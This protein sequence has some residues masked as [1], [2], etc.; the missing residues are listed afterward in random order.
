MLKSLKYKVTFL[1][2]G[3]TLLQN[4]TF[5]NGFGAIVGPNESGKSMIVE[6]IRYALFGTAALRGPLSDYEEL[7]VELFLSIKDHDYKI[8]RSLK[9]C[10]LYGK[11]ER[12]YLPVAVGSKP[13]NLKVVQVLGFGM[14]VFDVSCVT[15]QGEVERLGSMRPADR[16]RMV[17]SVIGM[18]VIEDLGKLANDEA[19]QHNR[20]AVN[21]EANL[22]KPEAPEKPEDYVENSRD[23]WY[24]ALQ[25]KSNY[26]NLSGKLS[27]TMM[28]PIEPEKCDLFTL[29][30]LELLQ[31]EYL[32]VHN[33]IRDLDAKISMIQPTSY[34]KAELSDMLEE[35]RKLESNDHVANV[36]TQYSREIDNLKEHLLVCP[37]CDHKFHADDDRISVLEESI[38]ELQKELV[39]VSLEPV[40]S[41]AKIRLEMERIEQ[42]T[43]W[44]VLVAE[45]GKYRMMLTELY[46]H[47]DEIAERQRYDNELLR[48]KQDTE[49]YIAWK[50]SYDKNYAQLL[51]LEVQVANFQN[52]VS[53]YERCSAYE[54]RRSAFELES[55][56]YSE[57]MVRVTELKQESEDWKRAKD[58]LLDLRI[59]IKQH[60]L[61]SLNTWSSRLLSLMTNGTRSNITV[62]E[63]FD[64]LVDGQ[65][66]STLSGSGKAVANLALRIGL[67]QVL[68]NGVLSLF[69]GDEIDASM[70]KDRAENTANTLQTLKDYVS[71]ILLVTH[72][73]PAADY[74]IELSTSNE[75]E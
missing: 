63:N 54:E 30:N 51:E 1:S 14:D 12:G 53:L 62:D 21:I 33:K 13:V 72:K 35:H 11:N 67:G 37:K 16:K 26:D 73:L 10:F 24:K 52:V 69:I 5:Q 20:D 44:D 47:S 41:I 34:T 31:H 2:T 68:T 17:D 56:R 40:L 58:A 8:T 42:H 65:N 49:R 75:P 27:I 43:V 18:S 61:P 36:I 46:D 28:E 70:D 19:N 38:S 25:A 22:R 7:E 9:S 3:K 55:Y 4:L 15:L 23:L 6:M 64:I 29:E 60:L 48:Y 71:Q 39:T 32:L 74:Y 50:E 57:A 66:L 59:K 45:R